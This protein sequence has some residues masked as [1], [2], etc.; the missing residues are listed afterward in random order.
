MWAQGPTWH[1]SH[2]QP[3][4]INPFL[5]DDFWNYRASELPS[6]Q[7]T[8]T[9][10]LSHALLRC[11]KQWL[12]ITAH[13]GCISFSSQHHIGLLMSNAMLMAKGMDIGW[14]LPFTPHTI[15]RPSAYTLSGT[16]LGI[17]LLLWHIS[18][19]TSRGEKKTSALPRNAC[20]CTG[21]IVVGHSSFSFFLIY[22]GASSGK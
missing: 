7:S 14:P 11:M 3:S 5:T 4:V 16:Y 18:T 15:L 8:H 12:L 6:H 1:S 10:P 17:T 13:V 22:P 9:S 21:T 19:S 20:H 2:G